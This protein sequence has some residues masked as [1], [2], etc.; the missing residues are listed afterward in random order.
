MY[1][2]WKRTEMQHLRFV[3]TH[4]ITWEC[5]FNKRMCCGQN[6]DVR[7]I[8]MSLVRF[9]VPYLWDIG[10]IFASSWHWSG[11]ERLHFWAHWG[12]EVQDGT[13]RIGIRSNESKHLVV[14]FPMGGWRGLEGNDLIFLDLHIP[15]P[16]FFSLWNAQPDPQLGYEKLLENWNM[17]EPVV[18]EEET[19]EE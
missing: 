17:L 3:G 8:W 13:R 5:P 4:G 10:R 1:V 14:D 9:I 6:R 18:L 7:W 2:A 19:E 11:H 15:S 12:K 16:R